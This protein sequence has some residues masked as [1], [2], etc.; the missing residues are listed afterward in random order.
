[1]T[2]KSSN[3]AENRRVFTFGYLVFTQLFSLVLPSLAPII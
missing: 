3:I 2:T 1:M